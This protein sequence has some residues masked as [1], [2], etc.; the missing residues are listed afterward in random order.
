M[1]P[2]V[3]VIFLAVVL[4]ASCSTPG[5]IDPKNNLVL[6]GTGMSRVTCDAESALVGLFS[7][8]D[9]HLS[10]TSIDG[11]SLYNIIS[12]DPE[13]ALITPGK[14]EIEVKYR[15]LDL[16]YAIGKLSLEAG[17]EKEYIIRKK[18][19]ANRTVHFWAEEKVTDQAVISQ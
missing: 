6:S 12:G 3:G 13:S 9:E 4:L 14:H 2:T 16:H 17:K 8:P 15:Y 11:K 10:I 5:A 19:G 7:R 1:I 18:T